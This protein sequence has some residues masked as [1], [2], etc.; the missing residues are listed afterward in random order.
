MIIK[1]KNINNKIIS[2]SPICGDQPVRV[3][4]HGGASVEGDSAAAHPLAWPGRSTFAA[5]AAPFTAAYMAHELST[6]GIVH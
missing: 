1:C 3:W 4:R 2:P 6:P 5:G